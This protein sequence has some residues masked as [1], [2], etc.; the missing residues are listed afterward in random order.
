[1]NRMLCCPRFASFSRSRF[2]LK[3]HQVV[4]S[5]FVANESKFVGY[6]FWEFKKSCQRTKEGDLN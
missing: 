5:L 6:S 2:N 3:G 1:M 4:L